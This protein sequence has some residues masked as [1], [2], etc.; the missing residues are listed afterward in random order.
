MSVV[1]EVF[2]DCLIKAGLSPAISVTVPCW[3]PCDYVLATYLLSVTITRQLALE[4]RN[5]RIVF[6]TI[7]TPRLEYIVSMLWPSFCK[8]TLKWYIN[9]QILS[10]YNICSYMHQFSH[11]TMFV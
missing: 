4:A 3:F 9:M 10:R 11:S 2:F 7:V 1:R 6:F 5:T 8:A